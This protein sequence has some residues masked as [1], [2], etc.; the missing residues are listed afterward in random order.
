MLSLSM[1]VFVWVYLMHGKS[2]CLGNA[3]EGVHLIVID[4]TAKA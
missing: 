4:N 2:S 3:F 1:L